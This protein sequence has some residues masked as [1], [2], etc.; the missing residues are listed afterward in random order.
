MIVESLLQVAPQQQRDPLAG[1]A[2]RL[3]DSAQAQA[4][5][6]SREK[7]GLHRN[8]TPSGDVAL[9]LETAQVPREHFS[10]PSLPVGFLRPGLRPADRVAEKGDPD[11]PPDL[12]AR[13]DRQAGEEEL[14]KTGETVLALEQF[15]QP[16]SGDDEDFVAREPDQLVA[17]AEVVGHGGHGA[18]ELIGDVAKAASVETLALD[19]PPSGS[20]NLATA[21]V[22]IDSGRDRHLQILPS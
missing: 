5:E 9:T 18:V 13:L 15:A 16:S 3:E 17:G 20:G 22:V 14:L 19:D 4:V 11:L 6:Q 21:G 8:V 7:I 10:E 2:V 1:V 12:P